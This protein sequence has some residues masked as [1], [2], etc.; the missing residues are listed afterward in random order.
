MSGSAKRLCRVQAADQGGPVIDTFA[1][2]TDA[3]LGK[4]AELLGTLMSEGLLMAY[5]AEAFAEQRQLH[6]Q[7]LSYEAL[8]ADIAYLRTM[9]RREEGGGPSMSGPKDW[10]PIPRETA[11]ITEQIARAFFVTAWADAMEERGKTFPGEELFS[12]A[13]NTPAC[14]LSAAKEFVR[15]MQIANKMPMDKIYAEVLDRLGLEDGP[16]L[17]DDFGYLTAMEALGSGVAWTDDYKPHGMKVPYYEFN[18][19]HLDDADLTL[20]EYT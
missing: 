8:A 2:L 19:C 13:P 5:K 3:Q 10:S 16:D 6:V 14:A 11:H 20:E 17:R 12:V 15:M 18:M 9:L 7:M 4:A 1:M